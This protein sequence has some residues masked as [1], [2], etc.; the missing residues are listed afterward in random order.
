MA[1]FLSLSRNDNNTVQLK[2]FYI[3]LW[4]RLGHYRHP[5]WLPRLKG[6]VHCYYSVRTNK[7]YMLDSALSNVTEYLCFD[8]GSPLWTEL[9]EANEFIIFLL[10]LFSL[11]GC[12]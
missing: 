8:S 3:R 2:L 7:L 11:D 9:T 6:K 1:S 12:R 5:P 4:A 10:V